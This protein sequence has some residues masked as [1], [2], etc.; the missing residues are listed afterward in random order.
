MPGKKAT[1]SAR[2]ASSRRYAAQPRLDVVIDVG[3]SRRFEEHRQV[4]PSTNR[5]F[6]T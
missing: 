3:L 6:D 1:T 4:V 2:P 5:S